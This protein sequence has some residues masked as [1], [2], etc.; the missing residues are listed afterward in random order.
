MRRGLLV[1]AVVLVAGC[2]SSAT[3]STPTPTGTPIVTDREV[4]TGTA[5]LAGQPVSAEFRVESPDPGIEFPITVTFERKEQGDWT[6]LAAFQ[7]NE[8]EPF[9][10]ELVGREWYR[11]TVTDAEN[12][13]C[14]PS[15]YQAIG[16]DS[17]QTLL[18]NDGHVK[19]C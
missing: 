12:T 9:T 11:I 6:E 2:S 3:P 8:G 7:V 15:L 17:N 16:A 1:L 10:V 14:G 4:T 5:S 13:V 19:S 18:I